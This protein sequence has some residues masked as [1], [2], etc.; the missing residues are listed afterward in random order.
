MQTRDYKTNASFLLKPDTPA[1]SHLRN[2]EA[3]ECSG[4]GW[5][6]FSRFYFLNISVSH[7]TCSL[8][9]LLQFSSRTAGGNREDFACSCLCHQLPWRKPPLYY[10]CSSRGSPLCLC[11]TRSR[12]AA[13][14][15]GACSPKLAV[16]STSGSRLL[17][18]AVS[19]TARIRGS[20]QTA[21]PPR[22]RSRAAEQGASCD[23]QMEMCK[24][25][26]TTLSRGY[27]F[28]HSL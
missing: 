4:L 17:S 28:P 15:G 18:S 5:I 26:N 12:G 16:I 3:P 25:T 10:P 20:G 2:N 1:Q 13:L 6:F 27:P 24:H 11:S 14:S 8:E 19:S 9:L 22:T 23:N 21:P 7:P